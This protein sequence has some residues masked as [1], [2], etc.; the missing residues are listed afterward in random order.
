MTGIAEGLA[1]QTAVK[2]VCTKPKYDSKWRDLPRRETCNRVQI[3]RCWATT[4]GK[5]WLARRIANKSGEMIS[6][7]SLAPR[8]TNE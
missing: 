2:L 7:I 3:Q 4:F 6:S 5:K 8:F 1:R